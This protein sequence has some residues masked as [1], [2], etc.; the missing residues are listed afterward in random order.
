M[1]RLP[2][3]LTPE[4]ETTVRSNSRRRRLEHGPDR[5][6]EAPGGAHPTPGDEAPPRLPTPGTKKL[7]EGTSPQV[8]M[9]LRRIRDLL[10]RARGRARAQ[11]IPVRSPTAAT[12]S[13]KPGHA[14]PHWA[15]QLAGSG[16]QRQSSFPPSPR[17]G[18][19]LP[20]AQRSVS[21]H[22]MVRGPLGSVRWRR[23]SQLPVPSS[24]AGGLT[25]AHGS[26]TVSWLEGVG[27]YLASA[28]MGDRA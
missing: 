12:R 19:T 2:G 28:E 14:R 15:G 10:S 22:M 20:S 11:P 16:G 9:H 3:A 1:L 5:G 4:M 13:S 18:R 7:M 27:S 17:W 8:G 26:A 21:D 24:S 25:T 6:R 23:S